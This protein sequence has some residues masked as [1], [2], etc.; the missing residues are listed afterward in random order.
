MYATCL[1][2]ISFSLSVSVDEVSHSTAQI[3]LFILPIS[4]RIFWDLGFHAMYCIF[5]SYMSSSALVYKVCVWIMCIESDI[6]EKTLKY[7]YVHASS[8]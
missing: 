1:S 8:S 6:F 5:V 2:Y 3:I 7:M 4:C